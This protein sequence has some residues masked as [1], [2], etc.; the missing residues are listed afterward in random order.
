MKPHI[1]KRNLLLALF[2]LLIF[3]IAALF[4]SSWNS[5]IRNKDAL[6]IPL[7]FLSVS[8]IIL[9]CIFCLLPLKDLFCKDKTALDKQS[10]THTES[11]SNVKSEKNYKTDHKF[12]AAKL[13][14]NLK[15]EEPEKSAHRILSN[16]AATFSIMQ[17]IFFSYE[18]ASGTYI[19][20]SSY[21]FARIKKPEPF[22]HG[23]GIH[24]QAALNKKLVELTNLPEEF[25]RVMS[26]LGKGQAS[27]LYLLPLVNKN[28]TVALIEFLTYRKID[29]VH[30]DALSMASEELAEKWMQ[31][32]DYDK[33]DK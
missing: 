8:Y 1:N 17:G 10:V 11:D 7:M 2:L 22:K 4:F 29:A 32:M 15:N 33:K 24:G 3:S 21:A 20:T 19:L 12:L 28:E 30:M 18:P 27:Y 9:I 23:A 31:I 6:F 16:L 13:T 25:T 14:A 5:F 26:G